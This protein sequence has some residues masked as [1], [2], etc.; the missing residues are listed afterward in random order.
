MERPT[1]NTSTRE[2]DNR[3]L[4]WG[5]HCDS[6][7]LMLI[8]SLDDLPTGTLVEHDGELILIEDIRYRLD[9]ATKQQLWRSNSSGQAT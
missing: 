7:R 1:R 4:T 5:G 8:I 3:L 9:Q 6:I 2:R